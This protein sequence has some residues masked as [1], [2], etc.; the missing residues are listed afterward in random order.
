VRRIFAQRRKGAKKNK[1]GV[2]FLRAFA[3]LRENRFLI[4]ARPA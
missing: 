3:S 4:P 1:N 2:D